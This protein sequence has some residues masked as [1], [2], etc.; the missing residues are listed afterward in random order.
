MLKI[1]LVGGVKEFH[2]MTFAE[3]FNGYDRDKAVSKNWGALYEARVGE[4]ARITHIWNEKKE[5]AE[6]VAEICNIENVAPDIESVLGKVDGVI[7]VDDCTMKHQRRAIPFLKAGI[8]TFIDKP[9][10]PDVKEAEEIVGL[11]R[12]HNTGIMSCSALRYAKETKEI[13]EGK[14]DL[15]KILTGF[16]ICREWQGSLIFY[17]I[18]AMELLYSVVG[19]GIESVRNI[20]EKA[21]DILIVKYKDGRK[22]I[23]SAYEKIAPTFQINL[24]GTNGNVSITAEDSDFFYSEMLRD[25][26]RMV[27][28]GKEPFLPD[29]TLEI[30]KALVIDERARGSAGS[31]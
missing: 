12:K 28:T 7:I 20:G 15:G 22:F 17:G 9:L 13:R 24:Y 31:D 29:E 23:V 14:H 1:G 4:D 27:K 18:H 26:V 21:K 11:A 3:M 8:P 2:G 25:F 30:I 10:S 6:E 5:D 19:P 16:A